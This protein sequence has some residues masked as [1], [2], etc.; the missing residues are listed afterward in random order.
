MMSLAIWKAIESQASDIAFLLHKEGTV[1]P[2]LN[3]PW[4]A[5]QCGIPKMANNVVLAI[6]AVRP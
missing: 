6:A 2:N 1:N 4:R 5:L 3:A